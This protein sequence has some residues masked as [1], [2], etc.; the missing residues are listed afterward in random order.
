MFELGP[1]QKAEERPRLNRKG[2]PTNRWTRAAIAPLSTGVVNSRVLRFA[3]PR[4]LHR[5]AA[6]GTD[7]IHGLVL[8]A[9]EGDRL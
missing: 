7:T 4:Q 6:R 3:P 2:N 1:K 8:L 9:L 5:S